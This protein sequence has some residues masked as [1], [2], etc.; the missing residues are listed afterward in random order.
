MSKQ[1]FNIEDYNKRDY[2]MH[3]NTQEK[4]D[5]FCEYLYSIGKPGCSEDERLEARM[6]DTFKNNTCY[7]FNTDAYADIYWYKK[8][9]YTILEFDDFDWSAFAHT[10]KKKRV[11]TFQDYMRFCSSHTS[12]EECSL[13]FEE[14][15]VEYMQRHF[16][17][18]NDIILKWIDEHPRKTRQSEFLKQ[19]PN[20]RI[21]EDGVLSITP[22]DIDVKIRTDECE[23]CKYKDKT[24]CCRAAYWQEYVED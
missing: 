8:N 12:C 19:Y 15:C 24:N 3:C 22:C 4:A 10:E 11:A 17:T 23:H 1:K 21:L 16:Q 13:F 14:R 9:G 7:N 5:I 20:A 6:W 18:A 2:V